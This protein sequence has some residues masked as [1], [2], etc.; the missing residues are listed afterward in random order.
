MTELPRESFT[1]TATGDAIIAEPVLQ[2]EGNLDEFDGLV[3]LLRTADTAITQL[4]VPLPNPDDPIGVPPAVPDQYQYLAA[5]PGTVMSAPAALLDELAGMGLDVYTAASNHAADFGP[6]GITSTI[7]ELEARQLPYAG[8]GTDRTHA[9]APAVH[10]TP[11]GRVSV[12]NAT[13]AVAPGTEATRP[14][15]PR[16]G[17]PGVNPLHL[18][19]RYRAP[20]HVLDTLKEVAAATGIERTKGTWLSRDTPSWVDDAAYYFMHMGFI[21]GDE[22]G[23]DT[24]IYD[25]D[26]RAYLDQITETSQAADWTIATLHTHQG[27][28]GTRNVPEVPGFLQTFAHE[29]ID[30]GADAFISTGPHVLR[31][32]EL[33]N[34]SPVFYSLGNFFYQI[35]L[36][37]ASPPDYP[38]GTAAASDNDPSIPHTDQR[39]WETIIPRCSFRRDG[40]LEQ[41]EV[42]PCALGRERKRPRRGVPVLATG[43]AATAT[44]DRLAALS[45]PFGTSIDADGDTGIVT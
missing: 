5:Y 23:I 28:N 2:Y 7:A 14:D 35:D 4:E 19:W 25:P 37:G 20:A 21:E 9:Q 41:L 30:A 8:I 13:T 22:P 42:Y 12:I 33:Y 44:I 10:H 32:I 43:D 27:P 31:G 17:K 3:N 36:A 1:L 24:R 6:P 38:S 29:C 16:N 11:G 39:R 18:R 40:S 15:P 34:D 45:A 26:R